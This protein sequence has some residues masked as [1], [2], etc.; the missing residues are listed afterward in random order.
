M[1]AERCRGVTRRIVVNLVSVQR[2]ALSDGLTHA[3][4]RWWGNR[5]LLATGDL[6]TRRKAA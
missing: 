4:A 6:P 2:K 5:A 1:I 3:D